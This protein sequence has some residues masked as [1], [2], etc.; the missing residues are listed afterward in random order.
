MKGLGCERL[1]SV[2]KIVYLCCSE[3]AVALAT[4]GAI[5]TLSSKGFASHS[6]LSLVL[7]N[8][9]VDVCAWRS[10]WQYIVLFLDNTLKEVWTGSGE[11]LG[12]GRIEVGTFCDGLGWN[13]VTLSDQLVVG[14]VH[15]CEGVAVREEHLL[16]LAHI[17]K[18]I[19]VEQ[20]NL[21][22]CALLHDGAEFL[23]G[24]LQ[25]AIA[26]KE[27]DCT[28]G[29]TK[30]CSDGSRESEAHSA[31]TAG[32]NDRAWLGELEVAAGHQL[33]L[34]HICHHNASVLSGFAD[35]ADDL[36][37]EE[38]AFC[39]IKGL[40]Y[41]L[42]VFLL[43]IGLE[44]FNPGRMGGLVDEFCDFSKCF[45]TVAEHGEIHLHILIKLCRVYIEVDNL[46]LFSISGQ[47]AC[48]TVVETHAHSDEEVALV[49]HHIWAEVAMHAK[50][51]L[52]ERMV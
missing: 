2:Q 23:D 21:D 33:V 8:H 29:S 43:F 5:A 48:Y 9:L 28:V 44:T 26:H 22:R 13:A 24:H 46:C 31:K 16:P 37:H 51:T 39:R 14:V 34:P 20:H 11:H 1:V 19:V 10:D 32:S 12:D 50:D 18:V 4:S 40:F 30:G 3:Q 42:V 41:N 25:T 45:L 15:W 27:A 17:A 36:T 35:L 49:G 38:R 7:Q 47:V 6:P 52:V